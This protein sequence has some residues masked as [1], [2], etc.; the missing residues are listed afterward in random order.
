MKKVE[1]VEAVGVLV[2]QCLAGLPLVRS[3]KAAAAA[4]AEVAT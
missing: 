1:A 3:C 2:L 4:V